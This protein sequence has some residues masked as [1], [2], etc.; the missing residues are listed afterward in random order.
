MGVIWITGL[1]GVGK[2]SAAMLVSEQLRSSNETCV[3][4]DGDELRSA[5]AHITQGYDVETRRRLAHT[6]AAL[7]RLVSEQGITSIVATVSLFTDVH[8]DNHG[9]I[10]RYLE[11]HLHCD[12][13]ERQ[14]RRPTPDSSSGPWVGSDIAFELPRAPHLRLDSG[15]LS[16]V[17]ISAAI[18]AHWRASN[19]R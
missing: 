2:T 18:V 15:E 12:E 1:P 5:L 17:E 3:L 6:Y 11:V 8:A 4:L 9:L 10:P 16:P 7:A 14:R 19:D 13:T